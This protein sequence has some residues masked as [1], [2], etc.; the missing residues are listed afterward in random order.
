LGKALGRSKV[1]TVAVADKGF[2]SGIARLGLSKS[3]NLAP[4]GEGN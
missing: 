3:E 2:V 1:A 4:E